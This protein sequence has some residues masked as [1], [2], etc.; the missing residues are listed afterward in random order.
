MTIA[1]SQI[2]FLE[3]G[4]MR[5]YVEAIQI[6]DARQLC[7]ARPVLLLDG[8][9]TAEDLESPSAGRLAEYRQM[10]IATAA[11]CPEASELFCY[12]LTE[13]PDLIWPTE[14]FEIAL[15]VD[16]FALLLR[17]EKH[18]DSSLQSQIQKQFNNFVRSFWQTHQTT[19][20][21]CA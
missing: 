19:F 20:S 5:L 6:V 11:S 16:F 2:L 15:D 10:A 3:Q 13:R 7:W 21:T 9:P 17:V 1:P 18:P 8:L 12:D 14:L 4:S